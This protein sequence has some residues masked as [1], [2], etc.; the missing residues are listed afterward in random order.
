MCVGSFSHEK[1]ANFLNHCPPMCLFSIIYQDNPDFPVF[2]F[3][4]REESTDRPSAPPEI[5]PASPEKSSWLGGRDLLAG[6]TWLGVNQSGLIAA[7]TNRAKNPKPGPLKSRGRL[8]RELL[9]QDSLEAAERE[10]H[11]QWK[12]E[13]FAGFNLLLIAPDRGIV[14]SAGHSLTTEPIPPGRHAITNGDWN[15]PGDKRLTRTRRAMDAFPED[16]ET[17]DDWIE[18]AKTHCGLGE[19]TGNDAVCLPCDRGWGT[20]S[21]SIIA[22]SNDPARSRYLHAAGSPAVVP[23]QDYS[24]LLVSLLKA[25]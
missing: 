22:L 18:L 4:N 15:D 24:P 23:Y 19:E 8:C 10:F 11:R 16:A 25:S 14:I 13:N 6:G 5:V 20:V 12:R 9:E 3:A 1:N 17:I 2:V 7:V 21:S